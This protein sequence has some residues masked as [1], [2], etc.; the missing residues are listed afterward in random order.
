MTLCSKIIYPSI[1]ILRVPRW[2]PARVPVARA[3]ETVK[4]RS[5]GSPT[6]VAG[7]GERWRVANPLKLDQAFLKVFWGALRILTPSYW[8]T[9]ETPDPPTKHLLGLKNGCFWTPHDIWRILRVM[10][11]AWVNTPFFP[12]WTALQRPRQ[13]PEA[14]RV[15]RPQQLKAGAL[16]SVSR[17]MFR[18]RNGVE[19]TS[20]NELICTVYS[21]L[22]FGVCIGEHRSTHIYSIYL[23]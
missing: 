17:G 23:V 8:K 7:S 10:L 1:F 15:A 4:S 9:I 11:Q 18:M 2:W 16:G 3:I 12:P 13:S 6:N 19:A 21:C 14:L 22:F 5:H 20:Q